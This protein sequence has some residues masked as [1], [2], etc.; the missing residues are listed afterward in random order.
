LLKNAEEWS[1][2]STQQTCSSFVDP[3]TSC[4]L[5]TIVVKNPTTNKGVPVCFFITDAERIPVIAQW[6][7]WVKEE[8][9]DL[10]VKKN[11]D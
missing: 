3:S 7:Q 6:L 1:V 2:D 10:T 8:I 4:F 11:H 5:F 9:P